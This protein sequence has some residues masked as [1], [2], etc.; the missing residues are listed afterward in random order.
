MATL[1]DVHGSLSA[2]MSNIKNAYKL[3]INKVSGCKIVSWGT[4]ICIN[5]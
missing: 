3:L 4:I 5:A 1:K 2:L